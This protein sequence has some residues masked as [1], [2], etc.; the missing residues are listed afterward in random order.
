M[1]KCEE[2]YLIKYMYLGSSCFEVRKQI[3]VLCLIDTA[4]LRKFF[5]AETLFLQDVLW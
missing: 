4:V 3:L 5:N 1:A 2:L